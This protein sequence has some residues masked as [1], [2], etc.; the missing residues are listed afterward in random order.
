MA[1]VR[2]TYYN[3]CDSRARTNNINKKIIV[4]TYYNI[5]SEQVAITIKLNTYSIAE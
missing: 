5:N 2:H 3:T 4:K 1:Y